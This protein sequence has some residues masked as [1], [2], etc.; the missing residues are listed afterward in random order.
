MRQSSAH[1]EARGS[2]AHSE[3]RQSSAHSI[4]A[5]VAGESLHQRERSV[6][7][8]VFSKEQMES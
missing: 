7:D 5:E 3:A 1:S 6:E 2:S 4:P 8:A